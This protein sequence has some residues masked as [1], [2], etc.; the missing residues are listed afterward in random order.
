MDLAII[1][2]N[3]SP[4]RVALSLPSSS[5]NTTYG[6]TLTSN[7]VMTPIKEQSVNAQLYFL[8]PLPKYQTEKPY[9]LRYLPP[10]SSSSASIP[11]TNISRTMHTL[12]FNDMRAHPELRYNKCGFMKVECKSVMQYEDYEDAE[13]VGNFH[14]NK[15]EEV[16]KQALVAEGVEIL[17]WVVS[18][19]RCDLFPCCLALGHKIPSV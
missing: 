7:S 17:D 1:S 18:L 2:S 5:F 19:H 4:L 10:P 11:Q 16:V 12:T 13:M 3:L 6:L 15:V 9:T 8:T 14:Q